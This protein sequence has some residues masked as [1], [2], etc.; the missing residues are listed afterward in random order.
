LEFDAVYQALTGFPMNNGT[1]I[2]RNQYYGSNLNGLFSDI[3]PRVLENYRR[4]RIG[5]QTVQVSQ[6]MVMK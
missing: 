2:N 3:D 1:N 6:I 4:N 5:H